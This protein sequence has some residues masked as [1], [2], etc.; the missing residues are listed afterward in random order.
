MIKKIGESGDVK[1]KN[2]VYV[3][4]EPSDKLVI[5]VETP[6]FDLFGEKI[7]EEVKEVLD[8]YN[9]KKAFVTVIEKNA[10]DFVLQARVEDA[11][12]N[13]LGERDEVQT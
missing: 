3:K 2:D 5:K 11:L 7:T 1:S 10:L 9:I 6:L 13:A 8:E 4:I 12:R